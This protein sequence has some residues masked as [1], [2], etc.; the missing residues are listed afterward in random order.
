MDATAKVLIQRRSFYS[1]KLRHF[2][3]WICKKSEM[4]G[5]TK[6]QI[7]STFQ[8]MLKE[9]GINNA[10]HILNQLFSFNF[11]ASRLIR[12]IFDNVSYY[13]DI[14]NKDENILKDS[15]KSTLIA[16][17][18]L[19]INTRSMNMSQIAG[20]CIFIQLILNGARDHLHGFGSG[21]DLISVSKKNYNFEKNKKYQNEL[22]KLKDEQEAILEEKKRE[23]MMKKIEEEKDICFIKEQEDA[24]IPDSWEDAF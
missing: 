16:L 18:E 3:S 9:L 8:S 22:K 17:E 20:I 2:H 13:Y 19:K 10:N 14:L 23:R 4:N 21:E 24:Q 11:D 12:I 6:V 15:I 1:N 7:R 5:A